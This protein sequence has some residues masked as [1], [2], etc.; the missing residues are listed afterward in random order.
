MNVLCLTLKVCPGCGQP[1]AYWAGRLVCF[2]PVCRDSPTCPDEIADHI[3]PT[4]VA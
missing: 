2:Y 4:P 3:A 1:L